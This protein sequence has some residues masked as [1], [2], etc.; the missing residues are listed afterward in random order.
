[1]EF[2]RN[3]LGKS[4]NTVIGF[5]N[6]RIWRVGSGAPHSLFHLPFVGHLN[7]QTEVEINL[8]I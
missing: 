5:V 6:V 7:R 8:L 2:S 4:L 3:S 1:M